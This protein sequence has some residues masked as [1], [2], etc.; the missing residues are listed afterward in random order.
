MLKQTK[1][2]PQY[3]DPKPEN[4][5][6]NTNNKYSDLCDQHRKVPF[7]SL[8]KITAKGH[9]IIHTDFVRLCAHSP[10]RKMF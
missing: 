3:M 1:A 10:T 2:I 8:A 5:N 9:K 4:N 6:D 7:P